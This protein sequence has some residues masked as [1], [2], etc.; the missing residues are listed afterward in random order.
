MRGIDILQRALTEE[1]KGIHQRR[2]QSLWRAVAGLVA[3]GQLC[4]TA[5]GRVLSGPTIPKHGIKAM[6]RLLG[7]EA[8]YAA[9][10]QVYRALAARYLKRI[11]HPVIA[12]DWTGLGAHHYQLSANVCWNGRALPVYA[13][14]VSKH[15]CNN[16]RV[17]KHFLHRLAGVLPSSC[18]PI[19]LTDAAFHESWF[20]EVRWL[21]WDF[22]GR[23]RSSTKILWRDRWRTIE[24]LCRQ[25]SSKPRNLGRCW[26]PKASPRAHR[27]VLAA[28]PKLR[29][30]KRLTRRGAPGRRA[31]DLKCS[32][33]ARQPW[34]LAT[35]LKSNPKVV[36]DAYRLRMQIEQS[37]RDL[38][39]YRH[40]WNM[41]LTRSRSEARLSVLLLVAAL[42]TVVVQ[43]V[44][45]AASAS[46]F[47]QLFQANTERRR[48]VLS[49]FVLGQITLQLGHRPEPVHLNSALDLLC[50]YIHHLRPS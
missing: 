36:V 48:R 5:I 49:F 40:G 34:L 18:K 7:S 15:L 42:A 23:V 2:Q 16:P 29:G 24:G 35:S 6:D 22:I 21:G 39:N 38:K 13:H 32:K 33:A 11:E 46:N 14:V 26:L 3:C 25:A 12:V 50:Q 44:G 37:F 30:R 9:R 10:D 8:L 1:L 4:L 19:L 28:R 43:L 31:T 45:L 47:A 41:H 17:L 20:E 27:L